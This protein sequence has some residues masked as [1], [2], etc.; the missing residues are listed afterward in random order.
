MKDEGLFM[1]SIITTILEIIIA[2]SS[3]IIA[4]VQVKAAHANTAKQK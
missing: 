4:I 1:F 3:L 2:A